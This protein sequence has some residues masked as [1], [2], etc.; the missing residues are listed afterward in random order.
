MATI[1][2]NDRLGESWRH[3]RREEETMQGREVV[4]WVLAALGVGVGVGTTVS[5]KRPAPAAAHAPAAP[6][7]VPIP[8]GSSPILNA[9][10]WQ[11]DE[12]ARVGAAE[13]A[14][15]G[16]IGAK[17]EPTAWPREFFHSREDI[18]NFLEK[19]RGTSWAKE[20]GLL[21]EQHAWIRVAPL[22]DA[23]NGYQTLDVSITGKPTVFI[24]SPPRA[25]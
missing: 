12:K 11:E 5:A 15:L 16:R 18:L 14:Y 25:P 10:R 3:W 19:E 9:L 24:I 7:D 8:D 23:G 4:A 1:G 20:Q 17:E 21:P 13:R 22:R 2:H 6:R